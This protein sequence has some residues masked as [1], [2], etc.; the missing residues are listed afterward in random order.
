[1]RE[2]NQEAPPLQGGG[3]VPVG[4]PPNARSKHGSKDQNDTKEQG[5]VAK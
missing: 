1:M 3:K 5:K 2:V 4:D